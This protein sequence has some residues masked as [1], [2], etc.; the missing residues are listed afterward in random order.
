MQV[1]GICP[2]CRKPSNRLRTCGMCGQTVCSPC[3]QHNICTSCYEKRHPRR[4][5]RNEEDEEEQREQRVKKR[6][7]QHK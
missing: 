3:M 2:L 1:S 6:K 7:E 5:L 4:F